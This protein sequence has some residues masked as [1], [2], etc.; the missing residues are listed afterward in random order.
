MRFQQLAD[1]LAW[2]EHAH[3]KPI[4]L[5][6]ERMRRVAGRLGLLATESWVLTV[7]GTNGKGSSV[8]YAAALLRAA[9]WSVGAYTSPHVL[10]YR[11]RIRINGA[12]V[13]ESDIV[14]AFDAIDRAR[15]GTSL[16]YFEFAT[17]AARWLFREAEV[18][19]QVL[20]VGLGGRLDAVN[21]F[22]PDVALVT[23]V[24]V[25]HCE[26]L[27]PDRESVGRE[28]AG[29]FRRGRPAVFA[30]PEL[31]DSVATQARGLGASLHVAGEDFGW[32]PAAG[33]CWIYRDGIGS[34]GPLSRPPLTGNVQVDN[35]AGVLCALRSVPGLVL[36]ES[37]WS[38]A[39]VDFRLCGRLQALPGAPVWWLDVAHN[40]DSARV[41]AD[42]LGA[43]PCAGRRFAC[44]G[45]M[46]RKD[47]PAVLEPLR[48]LF[49][50]WYLMALPGDDMWP[51][52]RMREA[53]MGEVIMAQGPPETLFPGIRDEL[54]PEDELV[55]FGSFRTVEEALRFRAVDSLE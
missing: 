38:R 33:D 12:C 3:P 4:D 22:D 46:A 2:Q 16:T 24:G 50:G 15:G 28:K 8:A 5:G 32:Q 36:S 25:D 52:E 9:G 14:R 44:I 11:E 29:I 18:G 19:A 51:P 21:T 49:H 40:P 1:W 48:G 45:L 6:H 26:W 20:E 53:L 23:S 35:A 30:G 27:G 10:E 43:R 37:L 54:G 47:L 42:A 7:A 55:A 34:V 39:M 13:D 41:L 17:L 31:P